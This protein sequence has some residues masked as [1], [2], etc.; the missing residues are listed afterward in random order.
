MI[1]DRQKILE[2]Y[3]YNPDMGILIAKDSAKIIGALNTSSKY[4]QIK[5][6]GQQ[7]LV[8]RIIYFLETGEQPE[9]VDHIDGDTRNNR[10]TNLRASNNQFNQANQIQHRGYSKY[11]G[12]C[13][14][15]KY[16]KA[17]IQYNRKS[18]HIGN[19]KTE[20]EAAQAYDKKAK[21]LFGEHARTNF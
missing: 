1:F 15:R 13:L 9:I 17:S 18:I 4:L 19:F 20:L 16:W 5:L 14:D 6:D 21:E 10:I 3:N 11:K 8:H 12:V 2:K 7:P